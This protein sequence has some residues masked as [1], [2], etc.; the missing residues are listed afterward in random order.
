MLAANA[1]NALY[2]S[3]V[4]RHPQPIAICLSVI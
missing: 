1:F 4:A 2:W 3:K